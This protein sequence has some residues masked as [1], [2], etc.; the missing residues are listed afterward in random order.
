MKEM[1]KYII[2]LAVILSLPLYGSGQED[3]SAERGQTESEREKQFKYYWYAAR[4]A[5]DNSRLDQA[6]VLYQFC[7]MINPEDAKTKETIGLLYYEAEQLDKAEKYFRQ[8][9]MLDPGYCWRA[10]YAYMSYRWDED[11]TK[12]PYKLEILEKAAE[13]NSQDAKLWEE[14]ASQYLSIGDW[15]HSFA[16]MDS[17][18]AINGQDARCALTRARIYIYQNKYK[19]ALQAL[20]D[21]LKVNA[22]EEDLLVMKSDL[23]TY[24][25][26]SWMQRKHTYER[27]LAL[28]PN[29]SNIL[30]NY[31]YDMAERNENIEQ[32]EQ[33]AFKAV[34]IDGEN[35]IILDTYAWILYKQGKKIMAQVYIQKAL[36]QTPK[37]MPEHRKTI[38][39]HYKKIMK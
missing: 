4:N 14:L 18:E 22:D 29:N 38:E 31:A 1:K 2:G 28:N 34:M 15:E 24:L 16:A 30:N 3:V 27:V 20:D 37:Y 8:A 5:Q 39:K 25:K 7:E 32:A 17:M 10:Y 11:A 21:Y 33:M 23:E 6:L 36:D 19:K 13:A 12:I 26:V 35:P 9:Y